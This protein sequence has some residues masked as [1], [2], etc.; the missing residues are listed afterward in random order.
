[1]HDSAVNQTLV[2]DAG[3]IDQRDCILLVD[4]G[5]FP[6]VG[7]SN[8]GR[9]VYRNYERTEEVKQGCGCTIR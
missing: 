9:W 6:A 2:C 8:V 3:E 5:N 4:I 1:M 7:E